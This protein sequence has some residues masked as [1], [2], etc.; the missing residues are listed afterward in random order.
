MTDTGR[1]GLGTRLSTSYLVSR[2]ITSVCSGYRDAFHFG[3]VGS[4]DVVRSMLVSQ[5]IPNQPQRRSLSVSLCVILK[6]IRA[7]VG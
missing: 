7:G 6:A 4:T 3:F 5:A 1:E 2:S